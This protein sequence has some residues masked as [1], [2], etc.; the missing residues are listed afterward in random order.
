MD[1]SVRELTRAVA[2][3][4]AVST[5][6]HPLRCAHTKGPRTTAILLSVQRLIIAVHQHTI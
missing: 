2:H 6:Q 1:K 3:D 4:S 5:A